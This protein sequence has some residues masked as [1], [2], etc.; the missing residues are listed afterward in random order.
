[1][2]HDMHNRIMHKCVCVYLCVSHIHTLCA[3]FSR[4][5]ESKT[6]LETTVLRRLKVKESACLFLVSIFSNHLS[7][8]LS[9]GLSV[10]SKY[11]YQFDSLRR[12]HRE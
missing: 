6:S 2:T 11:S 4:V 5:T 8:H 7:G 3:L 10:V 9:G 12:S 1:M